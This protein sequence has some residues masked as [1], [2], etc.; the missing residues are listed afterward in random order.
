MDAIYKPDVTAHDDRRAS[1]KNEILHE[2]SHHDKFM[3][4][5]Y[6]G[7]SANEF[8]SKVRH[9]HYDIVKANINSFDLSLRDEKGNT[10]LIVACQN[11]HK[12]IAALLV[13]HGCDLNAVNRKGLTA[14]DTADLFKF[15][16]LAQYLVLQ[17]AENATADSMTNYSQPKYMATA[18]LKSFR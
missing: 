15:S 5:T 13:D 6:T 12:K 16:S 2:A 11:N 7:M 14:L 3:N 18:D 4:T 1:H 10:A 8:F 17:G 9:N